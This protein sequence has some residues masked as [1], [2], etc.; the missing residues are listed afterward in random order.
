MEHN[1]LRTLILEEKRNVLRITLNRREKMNALNAEM[2]SELHS[3]LDLVEKSPEC[4][5]LI[6]TGAGKAFCA[7]G[8]ISE[9][10]RASA[11]LEGAQA[12]LRMSHRLA[13]R[14]R[15]LK[16]PIIMAVNGAAVG[17]GFSLALNGDIILASDTARFGST[18]LR[19]GLTPDLGSIHTL[20]H[21]LG[22]SKA[23]EL[24]FMAEIINAERAEKIGMVNRV[25][26]PDKLDETANDWANKI[27]GMPFLALG[28]LKRAIY[29]A[30]EMNFQS[31]LEDEINLQSLC[32]LS[33]DGREGLR[34]FLEKRT[35]AFNG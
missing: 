32:L 2:Y 24:T 35:P 25:V 21:L 20:V 11:T 17:A 14:L 33:K 19:V 4:R 10:S 9:L 12:R 31:E 16:Q 26:K 3:V 34:A 1:K 8:D 22:T 6:F 18:F 23:C 28:L 15:D 27:A 5:V 7:G 13:L 29:K 30:Q